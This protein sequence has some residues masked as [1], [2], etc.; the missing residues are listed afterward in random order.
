A[1]HTE[2]FEEQGGDQAGS[3]LAGVAVEHGGP[4]VISSQGLK[5]LTDL[6]GR[7]FDQAD[8]QVVEEA[9]SLFRG[10]DRR[11]SRRWARVGGRADDGQGPGR[12]WVGPRGAFDGP[13][14]VVHGPEAQALV[15]GQIVGRQGVKKISPEPLPPAPRVSGGG[16][17][18]A[19]IAK[20]GGAL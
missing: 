18:P 5:E 15:K 9:L 14:R 1:R 8:V 16:P 4:A 6:E 2:R 19:E 3:V 7:V 20:I 12:A 11:W 13:S 10:G 17:V